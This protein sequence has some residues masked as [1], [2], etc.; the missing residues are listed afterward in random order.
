MALVGFVC[1]F[2][3][4]FLR[5]LSTTRQNDDQRRVDRTGQIF[6]L[7]FFVLLH[8]AL[9]CFRGGTSKAHTVLSQR[10]AMDRAFSLIFLPL[11]LFRVAFG[12]D[13]CRTPGVLPTYILV[14]YWSSRK[15]RARKS[16]HEPNG[17]IGRSQHTQDSDKRKR[18]T[19]V[20]FGPSLVGL[21]RTFKS[22]LT[23]LL[24]LLGHSKTC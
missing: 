21:G 4:S 9:P 6:V 11:L 16:E 2:V 22:E 1:S 8:R 10:I 15:P 7:A 17:R 14:D 20:L 18:Q 24:P 3:P 23:L 13:R 19:K 12:Q 5:S